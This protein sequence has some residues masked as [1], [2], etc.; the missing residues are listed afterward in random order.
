[1]LKII[2]IFICPKNGGFSAPTFAFLGENFSTRRTLKDNQKPFKNRL[3]ASPSACHRLR[4]RNDR[5]A[6]QRPSIFSYFNYR[7]LMIIVCTARILNYAH[8]IAHPSFWWRIEHCPTPPKFLVP[9]KSGTR[10][11]GTRAKFLV[12]VSGTRNLG[13]ELGSCAMG[14]RWRYVRKIRYNYL[15]KFC[16]SSARACLFKCLL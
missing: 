5:I 8:K 13:G 9:E 10:M 14:L 12:P 3:A 7:L 4:S 11:H 6:D 1:M 15:K 2:Y 16:E